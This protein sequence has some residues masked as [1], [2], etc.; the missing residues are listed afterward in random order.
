MSETNVKNQP[1]N[2]W[3]PHSMELDHNLEPDAHPA[4]VRR[5]Q[6]DTQPVDGEAVIDLPEGE[7]Q[8]DRQP[9]QG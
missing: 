1:G 4:G 9:I 5:N 2:E 3:A 6:Q 7:K 8:S